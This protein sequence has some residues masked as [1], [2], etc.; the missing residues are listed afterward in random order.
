MATLAHRPGTGVNF[1]LAIAQQ[2]MGMTKAQ[3][4]ARMHNTGS[5]VDAVRL[6]IVT[7]CALA[8]ILAGPVLP[9]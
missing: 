8:L 7:G 9:F 5:V 6:L 3:S 1:A 2:N 4:L